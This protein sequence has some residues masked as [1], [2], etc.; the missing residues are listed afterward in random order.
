M[1][2]NWPRPLRWR[3]CRA[4]ST[5]TAAFRPVTMSTTGRPT[6]VAGPSASPLTLISPHMAWAQAS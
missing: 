6:R 2:R 1:S 5:A 3:S 4:S